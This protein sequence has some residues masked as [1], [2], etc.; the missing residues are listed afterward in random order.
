[1]TIDFGIIRDFGNYSVADR[2]LAVE[3]S[4]EGVS[5]CIIEKSKKI[6]LVDEDEE[7]EE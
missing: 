4:N 3:Y 1:M 6:N 2:L 7:E 5:S